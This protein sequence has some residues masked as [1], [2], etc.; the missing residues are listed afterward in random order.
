MCNYWADRGSGTG[1]QTVLWHSRRHCHRGIGASDHRI[2]SLE[3]TS[4]RSGQASCSTSNAA[5]AP[6]WMI[7]TRRGNW[8][9]RW[10]RLPTG[11]GLPT[12]AIL[13][14][15]NQPLASAAG[16]AVEIE[17]LHR[18]PHWQACRFPIV[19]CHG[20]SW[21][22]NAGEWRFGRRC[23]RR[24]PKNGNGSCFRRSSRKI[25]RHGSG[26][27]RPHRSAGKPRETPA[28]RTAGATCLCS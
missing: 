2:H 3:K 19:G 25:C 10:F 28:R 7:R 15:M 21:C 24:T 11:A 26:S 17:Q 8:P 14:D 18:L 1:G 12:T 6:S 5:M 13:T 16:N 20:R 22:G 23:I 27:G 9:S 4:C